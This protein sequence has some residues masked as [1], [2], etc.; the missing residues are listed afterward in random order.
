M[1]R[2]LI[3]F[4][5]G[6][7]SVFLYYHL[8]K[9][10]HDLAI[11]YINHKLRN[12]VENDMNFVIEFA[13]KENINYYIKEIDLDKFS[14]NDA[15]LKRYEVL[16]NVR[17]ENN[18]EYI[19]TGHN[20]ND[21]VET[22]LF[23][24]IRGTGIEGLKGISKKREN[25]IRPILDY[26][27]EYIVEYLN[28]KG[29]KYLKDYT[30][31][32]NDYARNIIRNQIFPIMANINSNYI[33]NISRFI[34]L[35]KES[36]EI[37]EYI[38]TEL[39]RNNIKYSKNKVDEIYNIKDKNGSSIKLSKEYVWI[40]TYNYYGIKK[41][42]NKNINEKEIKLEL[43]EKTLFNDYEIHFIDYSHLKNYLEK[44]AYKIYNVG[45]LSNITIKKRQNGDRISSTK[46][47]KILIDNKVD[48]DIRDNLPIIWSN[49][50]IILVAD[51]KKSKEITTKIDRY[52]NYIAIKRGKN[53]IS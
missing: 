51:I 52:S 47:K 10:K 9:Q 44:K 19:A 32:S 29:I 28:N 5:G 24:L 13:N 45:I 23:R 18:Y 14:E 30:N 22:I 48:R 6:P 3:A 53:D 43:N 49:E 34:E 8:K 38:K 11:C 26:R 33:E 31:D 36:D 15:R 40:K 2:I 42:E 12:D 50:K 17:K 46:V 7:D 16:E 35:L 41:I 25:I 21:N 39:L 27:K 20:K 1:S 4:S 37:K